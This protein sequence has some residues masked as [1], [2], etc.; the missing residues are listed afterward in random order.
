[1]EEWENTEG[2]CE[3]SVM[4]GEGF[5]TIL[6]FIKK[7]FFA[8]EFGIILPLPMPS[9]DIVESIKFLRIP[10]ARMLYKLPSYRDPPCLPKVPMRN[11]EGHGD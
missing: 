4:R 10:R 3:H 2:D 8:L 1:M 9:Q 6:N 5:K 7:C 11:E